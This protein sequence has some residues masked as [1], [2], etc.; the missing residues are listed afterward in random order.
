MITLATII[1]AHG[2]IAALFQLVVALIVVALL[3]WLVSMSPLPE[4]ALQILKVLFIVSLVL[5]VLDVLRRGFGVIDI[6]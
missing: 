6:G 3:Y 1:V 2:L 4:P 5:I